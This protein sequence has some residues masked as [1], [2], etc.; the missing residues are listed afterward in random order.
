MG[1]RHGG[2][3]H[4][5]RLKDVLLALRRRLGVVV[6]LRRILES[7]FSNLRL[8]AAHLG[9]FLLDFSTFSR[10]SLSLRT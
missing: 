8:R 9:C 1:F 10:D 3:A 4:G 7:R 5:D 6:E 2:E